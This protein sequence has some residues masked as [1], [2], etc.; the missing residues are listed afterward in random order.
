VAKAAIAPNAASQGASRT[1]MTPTVAGI[2]S[3]THTKQSDTY[4]L[5]IPKI[6]TLALH[7]E[8]KGKSKNT[9]KNLIK[10]LKLLAQRA[11]L[12]KPQDIEQAIARYQKV[13]GRP[14][15]NN[16]KN[17]L[18]TSYTAYCKFT[19]IQWT[20]KPHYTKEEIA[21]IP[22]TAQKIEMFVASARSTLSLKID[23][24]YQ[25]G[26]RPIEIQG[27]KG[28]QV[29]N[30][31]L[32]QHLITARI[33]KGCN[34]RPPMKINE[35]L[36]AKLNTY[37]TRNKLKPDDN[38]FTGDTE[39]YSTHFIRFKNRLSERLKD[40]SIKTIRLYDIRHAYATRNLQKTQN[41]ETVRI[42][43]GHK[44]L[45]TTQR[46][47]HLLN[48]ENGE[49]TVEGTTDKK[50]AEELLTANFTYQL[51]TPDGTMLFRKPK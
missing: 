51:T 38:L 35:P 10:D 17:K 45:N 37:I 42:I 7:L 14:A 33:T 40:P 1:P 12:D 23:I 49:W 2:S 16:Y 26:L 29:K 41:T 21:I 13:N 34:P 47:L 3:E 32:E 6:Q 8:R 27:E 22:P 18:C 46:Y 30:I 50:R 4:H 43:M 5:Q 36:T 11:D 20:D 19:N 25:T 9:I 31:N 28:L 48:L 15:T 39:R 44:C 24:S